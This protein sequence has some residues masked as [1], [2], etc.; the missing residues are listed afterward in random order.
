[1]SCKQANVL[2]AL[3]SNSAKPVPSGAAGNAADNTGNGGPANNY[4][5]G[6]ASPSQPYYNSFNGGS[7]V[8]II[9]YK[10]QN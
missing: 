8:V 1:M 2:G 4:Y 10:Y 7:G 5:P 9:R 6:P 3:S